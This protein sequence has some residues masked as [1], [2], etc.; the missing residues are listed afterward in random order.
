MLF[1]CGRS[2]EGN[3]LWENIEYNYVF[4]VHVY[5]A[6]LLCN[7]LRTSNKR[8]SLFFDTKIPH[9]KSLATISYFKSN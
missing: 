7:K 5:W 6:G 9:S 1:V 4:V 3:Y 8:I 2:L